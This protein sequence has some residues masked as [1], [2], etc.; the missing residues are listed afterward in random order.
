[1]RHLLSFVALVAIPA[2]MLASESRV[3]TAVWKERAPAGATLAV[4]LVPEQPAI[5]SL[6]D[7]A[8]DLGAGVPEESYL[9]FFKATFPGALREYSALGP[10]VFPPTPDMG[11]WQDGTLP[12]GKKDEARLRIPADRT[13]ILTVPA[14]QFVLVLQNLQVS[15]QT[16][17]WLRGG[18]F[19]PGGQ[20]AAANSPP[21]DKLVHR[22]HFFLWDN[23][24]GAL[25]SYGWL[26]E[27]EVVKFPA[28]SRK[29]WTKV[30]HRMARSILKDTLLWGK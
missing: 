13:T 18:G 30:I 8:D 23:R 16:G 11:Q 21:E 6:K 24:S 1:M 22:A 27:E 12:L 25:V 17:D 15:R 20:H 28:M 19:G 14:T 4:I 9:R 26:D 5:G 29:T 7:V 10:V 3:A 2:S